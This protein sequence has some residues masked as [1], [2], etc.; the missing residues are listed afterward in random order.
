M[1]SYSQFFKDSTSPSISDLSEYNRNHSYLPQTATSSVTQTTADRRFSHPAQ[2]MT[3]AI[4]A[5]TRKPVQIPGRVG[6]PPLATTVEGAK[7]TSDTFISHPATHQPAD[8]PD[9]IFDKRKISE[10]IKNL[11]PDDDLDDDLQI[12]TETEDVIV[13][14]VEEFVYT[15]ATSSIQLAKHRKSNGVELKD[16][17]VQLEKIWNLKVPGFPGEEVQ[18]VR[19]KLA[20]KGDKGKVDQI[21]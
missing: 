18:G 15:V 20:T 11:M 8:K 19:Q 13:E 5:P 3:R 17:R 21:N 6:R 4:T 9:P 7:R 1:S 14:L 2:S 12:D 10:L 16:V